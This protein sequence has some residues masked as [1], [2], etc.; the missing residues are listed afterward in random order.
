MHKINLVVGDWSGDG[1]DKTE[2]ILISSSLEKKDLVKAYKAGLKATKIA[3]DKFCTEYEQNSIPRSTYL[4]LLALDPSLGEHENYN[5]DLKD[6]EDI[7]GLTH[8]E[9]A[10]MYMIIAKVGNP[11][12][13]WTFEVTS[14]SINIGGYGLFY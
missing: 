14:D 4:E 7:W 2:D 12:L 5:N 9:F 11:K 3:H 10:H 6:G 8:E 13:K 1:H